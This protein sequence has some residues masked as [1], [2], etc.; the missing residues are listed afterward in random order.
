MAALLHHCPFLKSS[1]KPALRRTGAALL[2][3]AYRC[4]I[5]ARQITICASSSTETKTGI[6]SSQSAGHLPLGLDSKRHLAKS[7]TQV[8]VSI[9]NGCPFVSSQM[10]MVKASAEVQEDVE[11]N[12]GAMSS[13]LKGLKDTVWPT[14]Q[15]STVSHLLKDNMVGPSFDYDGFFDGKISEKKQD[16]TYRV[17]KTVNRSADVFPFAEDYSVSG[18]E[19]AQV[20]VWCSNDYLGMSRHPRVLQGIR[21]ALDRHGAGAGGTRNISGTSNFHVALEMELAELH[22][23]DAALVFSSCF[24]ANDS[25]LFT[26]AKML[27]GCEIYS[28]MGNHASMIQGI[29]NSG[30]KRHIFRH[31][32]SRHL[33]ELL[34]RSNPGTP[35]IVA[36]ETVHSMDGEICPL[37]ELCDVAHRYGALTFVDEVHAVGLYGAHGA[38]VGQ[39]DNIM[40]KLDIVSGTLGKAFGCVG[41]YIASSAALVDTVRSFAAGFIFTTSL[42]PMVLSGALES[43]KVLRGPEGHALRRAHQRNVKHMRQ[44]LMDKGLPV[45]NCP[46]HIIPIRVGDAELN[47]RVCDIL[48]EKHNI[49]VQAINYPTVPRGEELLR[50]APSPHHNPAMMEYFVDKLVEVW[51]EAGLMQNSPATFSCTFCDRPLHFDL[52]SEWEKSYFGN[53]EPQYIT[54]SA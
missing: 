48:L 44:L 16:H 14:V 49:Y 7:A 32:D 30:A 21:D 53:M 35:K 17:F 39:R 3:L 10:G 1:H 8:S 18:R 40:H 24:V 5:V 38:G 15:P 50:L 31:N 11:S 13:L 2:S 25:T 42:P 34:R 47:S 28:D 26:M 4:P 36:F 9:S 22:Q 41:G 12:T 51:Q 54:V 33:E 6:S 52:M 20:S 46:S 23:K 29:R 37:E 43:V 19:G 45:V 27:P